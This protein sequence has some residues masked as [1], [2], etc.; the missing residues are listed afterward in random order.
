MTS[1]QTANNSS[2]WTSWFTFGYF[3]GTDANGPALGRNVP[4]TL[5][6]DFSKILK[7]KEGKMFIQTSPEELQTIRRNLRKP[8][9][10][11]PIPPFNP[12][13][14]KIHNNPLFNELLTKVKPIPAHK[15]DLPSTRW[16]VLF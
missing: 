16:F 8:P 11:A 14:S 10:K 9:P 6:A 4:V 2:T 13:C 1:T 3:G 7:T 5:S 12:Y 15:E